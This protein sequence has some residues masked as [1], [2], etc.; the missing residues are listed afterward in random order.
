MV[1]TL[2]ARGLAGHDDIEVVGGAKDAFEARELIIQHRPDVIILDIEMP[3]MDGITFL[4][5]LMAHYPVPVIMCSAAGAADSQPA[6]EAIEIGAI[7]VVAKPSGG[8]AALKQLGDDLAEKIRAATMS[9]PGPPPIPAIATVAPSSFRAAGLNPDDY[10]VAIGASTGGTEAIR[11]VLANVPADFPPV[12][13]VQH[14]PA[15]FTQSFAGR[16]DQFSALKVREAAGD[17]VLES[18]LAF[19]A[20]GGIQMRVQQQGGR[21]RVVYGTSEPVNRHC[22]SVDVLFDSV[23]EVTRRQTVGVLLTG[24]GADGARGLLRMREAG[25]VTIAQDQASCVVYGMPK[26]AVEIGA[27]RHRCPPTEV[28]AL[29]LKLLVAGVRTSSRASAGTQRAGS[30]I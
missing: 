9:R 18:G 17:E 19:L 28:G 1:R 13:M 15:G 26:V 6:L 29:I 14:M 23:A 12:V 7:D 11:R 24:M 22:P 16:L 5:K 8:A 4:R 2:L 10:L 30:V 21:L 27:A 25:A 20:R 3:R